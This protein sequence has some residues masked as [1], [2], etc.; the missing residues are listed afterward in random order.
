M[1]SVPVYCLCAHCQCQADTRVVRTETSLRTIQR[2][3]IKI[4]IPLFCL[5][6]ANNINTVVCIH[7]EFVFI[8]LQSI[9]FNLLLIMMEKRQKFRE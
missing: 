4:V 1:A 8:I 2:T 3:Q 6:A 9:I 7:I 5:L